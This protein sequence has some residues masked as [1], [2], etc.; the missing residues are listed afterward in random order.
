VIAA[1]AMD[2][3]RSLAHSGCSSHVCNSPG[4]CRPLLAAVRPLSRPF[5]DPHTC[6]PCA[7][8]DRHSHVDRSCAATCQTSVSAN[9]LSAAVSRRAALL[10]GLASLLGTSS[11]TAAPPAN[12]AGVPAGDGKVADL[13]VHAFPPPSAEGLQSSGTL[14]PEPGLLRPCQQDE[15]KTIDRC[16]SEPSAAG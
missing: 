14:F 13:E 5:A 10:A 15:A 1:A 3:F 8:T 12:A 16:A 11:S 4:K 6:R 2:T 7:P 9:G